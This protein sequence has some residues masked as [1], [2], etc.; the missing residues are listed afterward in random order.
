MLVL[1]ILVI[2]AMFVVPAVTGTVT[3]AKI[4]ATRAMVGSSG[5]L[6]QQIQLFHQELN[7]FPEKLTDLVQRPDWIPDDDGRWHKF[8]VVQGKPFVDSWDRELIYKAPGDINEDGFDLFSG[9]P[10]GDENTE[11]DN[12]GNFIEEK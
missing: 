7:R 9:G 8:I 5:T 12:I 4:K 3:I 10:D 11:E 2:L 6:S 1:A